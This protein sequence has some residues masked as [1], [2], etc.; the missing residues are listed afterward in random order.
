[1]KNLLLI[2]LIF[3]SFG[4]CAQL[5][6][7]DYYFMSET[8]YLEFTVTDGGWNIEDLRM[9]QMYSGDTQIG[10]GFWHKINTQG[11][12]E[13]YEGPDGFYE[14][15]TSRC[16]FEFDAPTYFGETIEF[17]SECFDG[18]SEFM[19]QS[20]EIEAG[21]TLHDIM[22][23]A[24]EEASE[25]AYYIDEEGGDVELSDEEFY[26]DMIEEEEAHEFDYE[27]ANEGYDDIEAQ[28]APWTTKTGTELQEAILKFQP[29]LEE[30]KKVF[31]NEDYLAAYAAVTAAFAEIINSVNKSPDETMGYN[32]VRVQ[33]VV[34]DQPYI[35]LYP[36]K[37][38]FKLRSSLSEYYKFSLLKS[39]T[40]ALGRSMTL[41]VKVGNR[42]VIFPQD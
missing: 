12:D 1:M 31:S 5:E 25:G 26:A 2:L 22:Y 37:G 28:L 6:D 4:I 9:I 23:G 15:T 24:G 7:G 13:G 39:E 42:Y 19:T 30:C 34:I 40:D 33:R 8:F 20:T 14:F 38:S 35:K 21:M 32:Y 3:W 27:W 41:I 18:G 10:S 29:T 36:R 16:N 17:N 11:A